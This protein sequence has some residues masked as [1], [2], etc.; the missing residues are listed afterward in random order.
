MAKTKKQ[1][2]QISEESASDQ[3]IVESDV[4]T[5][6]S[7]VVV[8]EKPKKTS[9]KDKLKKIRSRRY[10]ALLEFVDK[11]QEYSLEEA[12]EILKKT[13][14]IKFSASVEAHINLNLDV[15]KSDQQMRN[16][17]VLPHG[18][19]KEPKI[20]VFT[21]NLSADLKTLG[22]EFGDKETLDKISKTGKIDFDKVIA[23]P[24]M[25]PTLSAAAKVLGPK[26]L[27]PNPKTGT[28]TTDIKKTVHDL[29]SGLIE[30]RTE[31]KSPIVHTTIGKVNIETSKLIENFRALY[32]AVL[33]SRPKS[34]K[35]ELVVSV[36]LTTTMGPSI[37]LD[38]KKI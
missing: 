11:S 34:A 24:D 37:R 28:V 35:G 5:N 4:E 3:P 14:T 26:G 1:L 10:K 38:L 25:M 29:K 8:E 22:V 6:E 15:S 7:T 36:Y 2:K 9:V 13:S 17:V 21:G 18:S 12:V 19:G 23:T 20:L 30:F 32:E 33:Q 31:T 16:T 27:M